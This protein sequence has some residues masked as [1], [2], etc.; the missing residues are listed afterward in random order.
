MD[1]GV[2]VD[3]LPSTMRAALPLYL[4]QVLFAFSQLLFI[5]GGLSGDLSITRRVFAG[6]A[7][8]CKDSDRIKVLDTASPSLG[9]QSISCV[10]DFCRA[11]LLLR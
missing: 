2:D 9:L 4:R 7:L 6:Q 3:K 10:L 11:S 1:V 8:H 5:L